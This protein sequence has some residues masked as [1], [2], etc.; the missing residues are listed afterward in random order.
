[1]FVL[2]YAVYGEEGKMLTIQGRLSILSLEDIFLIQGN[3]SLN[4]LSNICK[5]VVMNVLN[6]L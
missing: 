2:D 6:L 1:M 5:K 3:I 4:G